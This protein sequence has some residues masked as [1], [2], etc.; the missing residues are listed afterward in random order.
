MYQNWK[1]TDKIRKFAKPSKFLFS[2]PL[3]T[4]FVS[5]RDS[6]TSWGEEASLGLVESPS[7][8]G[9]SITSLVR[10]DPKPSAQFMCELCFQTI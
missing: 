3:N 7:R 1:D 5:N 4:C 2:T 10:R 9:L 6:L 8:D